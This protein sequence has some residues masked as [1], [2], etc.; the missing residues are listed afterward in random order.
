[1]YHTFLKSIRARYLI[2]SVLLASLLLV[3]AFA[4]GR[5]VGNTQQRSSEE[6]RLRVNLLEH[7]R[8][9]RVHLLEFYRSLNVY[10]AEPQDE[11]YRTDVIDNLKKSIDIVLLLETSDAIVADANKDDINRILQK[12]MALR[13][14]AIEIL[15][16]RD[17]VFRMYPSL[18]VSN[19][20]M[21]PARNRMNNA[22]EFIF[23]QLHDDNILKTDPVLYRKMVSLRDR[24]R[25]GLSVFR[26][27][28]A[29]RLGSFVENTL[30]TQEYSILTHLQ[31]VK[32]QL[33]SIL[34]LGSS[35][36]LGFETANGL[37]EIKAALAEF[38]QGFVRV[39]EIHHS[40]QWRMDTVLMKS[41]IAPQIKQIASLL[42]KLERDIDASASGSMAELKAVANRQNNLLWIITLLGVASILAVLLSM[43]KMLLKPIGYVT[44][45]LKAQAFGKEI[46][47]LPSVKYVETKNLVDAFVEMNRQI[48]MRQNDLEHQA[49][50][51][52][53]TSLPNRVL[54]DDRIEYAIKHAERSKNT[55]SLMVIDLD[56]FKEV[57]DTLGHHVGDILLQDVSSRLRSVLRDTDTIARLGG[58]E[59]AILIQDSNE[60]QSIGVADKIHQAFEKT[61]QISELD[62]Y[63]SASIG[64]AMFPAHGKDAQS[65]LRHADIAM[66]RAKQNHYDYSVYNEKE[67]EFSIKHLALIND[68][69][70]GFEHQSLF[71]KYQPKLNII[72]SA[73][74]GVEA[75]LRWKHKKYGMIPPDELIEMAEQT[76]MIK[77]LTR[78][79]LDKAIKQC[80]EWNRQGMDLIISVNLSVYNLKDSDLVS[81]V[82]KLLKHHGLAPSKLCLEITE[83]A[84]MANPV[85]AIET[86]RSLNKMGVSL[87]IDDFG[88]GF[89]SLAYL[90]QMPVDEIKIDKSFV[91]NMENDEDDE[92]IVK[93]TVDLA[94]NLGLRVT[95]EGVE[96]ESVWSQLTAM[97]CDEV[98]G[99]LMSRPLTHEDFSAWMKKIEKVPFPHLINQENSYL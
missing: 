38:E 50:H 14:N 47:E 68:L 89:S 83:S 98:Q 99:Y 29:N 64:I 95:A 15:D 97:G 18:A 22:F 61:S 75:L 69:R 71:I 41:T 46:H 23:S 87:A 10:L 21:R 24:W 63:V 25:I 56:N 59:F 16:V 19:N 82:R 17:D 67:D 80:A 51:D 78:W 55:F 45:A 81:H 33:N 48:I 52:G 92:V 88:T 8:N 1:M 30:T 73:V 35:G 43:E 84:M 72:S 77:P 91:I 34:Q 40:N 60:E 20:Q 6:L 12:L 26:L 37:V 28:L 11:K 66:Y 94:H 5:D 4:G 42:V 44:R 79:V 90:K 62:L 85:H 54:L 70:N 27:Y 32:G 57:N 65:L 3:V 36:R 93:S 13:K 9:I 74:T 7:S 58:D 86:L 53:L 49:T 31:D 2:F 76:G 39:V 96:S